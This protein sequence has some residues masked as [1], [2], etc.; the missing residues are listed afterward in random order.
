VASAYIADISP[1]EHLTRRFGYMSACFGLGFIAGPVIGGLLGD[2][3]VRAPF[4]AAAVLNGLN[5]LVA[6]LVLPESHQGRGGRI[7][8]SSFNPL[9][10]MRWAFGFPA[11]APLLAAFVILAVVG[12]VGG[13]VWVLYGEDRF[14]WSGVTIGVSL[15]GFGL[16]HA[17]AQAFV[18]GPISERWGEK[19]ALAIGIV[20]D[21]I[22]Y[23]AIALVSRGW[24]AFL[25]LPLFCLGGVGGPALQSLL[26]SRAGE[27]HQGR[28][29]GVLASLTGV[30]SVIA[31]LLISQVYFAS[32]SVFP[33]LV[34]LAGAAL[35][36]LCLP[37]YFS[38]ALKESG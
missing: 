6:L 20:A 30:S 22:A 2:V 16:F 29:Q 3:W 5:F 35:Y 19:R 28:L 38:R 8:L 4:L 12:E 37:V 9:G 14:A 18:A 36:L 32:R 24:M 1:A 11:L 31:P 34:W 13:T 21:A 7:A 27:A 10:P 33:G 26:S 17:L 25:L 23:V 15:A